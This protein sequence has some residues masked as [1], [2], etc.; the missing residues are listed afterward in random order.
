MRP[1][2]PVILSA[3]LAAALAGCALAPPPER[4]ETTATIYAE[5]L[6]QGWSSAPPLA[7]ADWMGLTPEPA[8][9]A[10]VGEG[11]QQSQ[12]LQGIAA[13]VQAAGE[14][15][16]V[17]RGPALP[18]LGLGGSTQQNLKEGTTVLTAGMFGITWEID[19]WGR[20]R[21]GAAAA[22]ETYYSAADDYQFARLSLAAGIGKTWYATTEADAQLKIL[23]ESRDLT[24]SL[25]KLT[26]TRVEIGAA[27]PYEAAQL[28]RSL[29]ELDRQAESARLAVRQNRLA[30]EMLTGRRPQGVIAVAE[31]LPAVAPEIPGG[32]PAELLERRPDLRAAERRA[33]AAFNIAR[34]AEAARLPSI[35]LTLGMSTINSD[36]YVLQNV[37]NPS[38]SGGIGLNVPLYAG[39]ALSANVRAQNAQQEAARAFYLD[40]AQQAFGEVEQRLSANISL[41]DQ[42][43]AQRAQLAAARQALAIRKTQRE[44]GQVDDRAVLSEQLNVLA[45]ESAL[46]RLQNRQIAERIDLQLA[47]GGPLGMQAPKAD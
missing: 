29:A 8:L 31:E 18:Q 23:R 6:P 4:S 33:R 35:S 12:R 19:L 5:G 30:L 11:L 40:K 14:M 26:D 20:I 32:L 7:Y 15:V 45:Q 16:T 2:R 10:L 21:Y 25:L 41:I 47:L 3:A 46:L 43:Q 44:V 22:E 34:Q 9:V 36:I 28:R 24:A 42:M 13:Q 27:S 37:K 39:G 1:L 38:L 17:A